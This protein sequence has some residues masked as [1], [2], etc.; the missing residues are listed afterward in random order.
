MPEVF[1]QMGS[2]LK[3]KAKKKKT[4]TI[5]TDLGSVKYF[6]QLALLNN[7]VETLP[8]FPLDRIQTLE[9]MIG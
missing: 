2:A 9:A 8:S 6:Y 3:R 1:G 7:K 5:K 4:G